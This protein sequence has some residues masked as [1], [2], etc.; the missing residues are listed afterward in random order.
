MP[1]PFVECA[2]FHFIF[3]CFFVKN[4]MFEGVWIN[5]WVFSSVPLILLPVFMP[6]PGCFQY[7]SSVVEFEVRDCDPEVLLLY[8]IVLSIL[9]FLLFYMKLSIILLRSVKNFAGILLGISLNL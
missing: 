4:Q 3:L 1:A 2:F 9:V 7:C 6:K 8:K 5:I